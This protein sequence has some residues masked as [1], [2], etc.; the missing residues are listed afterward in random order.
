MLLPWRLIIVIV[1][2]IFI[3]AREQMLPSPP[4]PH[5]YLSSDAGLITVV[6][7]IRPPKPPA[8]VFSSFY[9][10]VSQFPLTFL[11]DALLLCAFPFLQN[12]FLDDFS[13]VNV[14]DQFCEPSEVMA[15][16]NHTKLFV[17]KLI[18]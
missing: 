14:L 12:H 5:C 10:E 11:D 16:Y 3:D 9:G 15:T 4:R 13:N 2:T 17:S 8:H 7:P 18:E 6:A 1:S